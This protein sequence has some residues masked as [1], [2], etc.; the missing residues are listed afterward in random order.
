MEGTARTLQDRDCDVKSLLTRIRKAGVSGGILAGY[1]LAG[2]LSVGAVFCAMAAKQGEGPQTLSRE[3]LEKAASRA[4]W[5]G[6]SRADVSEPM[7]RMG[8]APD[9]Y[10]FKRLEKCDQLTKAPLRL[11]TKESRKS[12]ISEK[13]KG[14]WVND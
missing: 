5:C 6:K 8:K 3:L 14:Q 11:V 1:F 12:R 4:A 7:S 9:D 10:E 13:R 2:R